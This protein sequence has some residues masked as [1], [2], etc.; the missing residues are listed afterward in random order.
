MF[1]QWR[2]GNAAL[3]LWRGHQGRAYLSAPGLSARASFLEVGSVIGHMVTQVLGSVHSIIFF[4]ITPL[5]LWAALGFLPGVALGSASLS[6]S[7]RPV[8]QASK[9]HARLGFHSRVLTWKES[10]G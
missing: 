7:L 9:Y 4:L 10:L 5:P 8:E 1:S 2:R 3:D 6:C